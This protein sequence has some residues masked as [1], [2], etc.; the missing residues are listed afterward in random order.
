MEQN[1]EEVNITNPSE[2]SSFSRNYMSIKHTALA[3]LRFQNSANQTAIT[4]TAFLKDLFE[5][6][7]LSADK[8]IFGP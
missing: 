6:G 1:Q 8:K 2:E 3:S 7:E 5:A 4:C